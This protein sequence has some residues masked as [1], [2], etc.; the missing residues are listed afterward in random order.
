MCFEGGV[1]QYGDLA[2]T[3]QVTCHA[4]GETRSEGRD[5]SIKQLKKTGEYREEYDL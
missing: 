2:V 1:L 4:R 5:V 3:L